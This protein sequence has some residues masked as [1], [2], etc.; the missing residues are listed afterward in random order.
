MSNKCGEPC[1]PTQLRY[2]GFKHYTYINQI[3]GDETVRDMISEEFTNKKYIFGIV[4]ADEDSGFD[5]GIHHVLYKIN[6]NKKNKTPPVMWCSVEEGYQDM[7]VNVNDTL[8]QSYTLLKYLN[9]PIVEDHKDRQLLMI[10]IYREILSNQRF[11]EKLTKELLEDPT[12]K[13]LWRDWLKE[14]YN[15]VKIKNKKQEQFVIMNIDHILERIHSTLDCWERYGYK[16]FIG[17]GKC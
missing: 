15:P 10:D 9:K 16:Y 6:K 2:F 8:C 17:D 4:P 5:N 11:I 12:N 1:T 13:N 14:Q 3:F 7:D